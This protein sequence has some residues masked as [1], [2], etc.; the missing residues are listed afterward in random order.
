M[1]AEEMRQHHQDQGIHPTT[2]TTTTTGEDSE[3]PSPPSRDGVVMDETARRGRGEG[4]SRIFSGREH[5]LFVEGVEMYCR[6]SS[7][8][9]WDEIAGHVRTR[10]PD[11]IKA[12]A[13]YYVMS[14]QSRNPD[15]MPVDVKWSPRENAVFESSFVSVVRQKLSSFLLVET[16]SFLDFFQKK[17]YFMAQAPWPRPTKA[18]L[19]DGIKFPSA[20]RTNHLLMSINGIHASSATSSTSNGGPSQG[21]HHNDYR[22]PCLGRK[23]KF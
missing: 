6:S 8:T 12:H 19:F 16:K 11:E 5:E 20:S 10:S 15:V 7:S 3:E 17:N 23:K 9:T 1:A 2:T 4:R 18:I 22:F 21:H 13:M 14:L